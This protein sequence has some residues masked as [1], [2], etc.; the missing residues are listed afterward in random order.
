MELKEYVRVIKENIKPFLFLWFL[1]VG[2]S[3]VIFIQKEKVF[4]VV[5]SLDLARQEKKV[6]PGEELKNESIEYDH[7]YRMEADDRFGKKISKWMEDARIREKIF[8]KAKE[9]GFDD[10]LE[11]AKIGKSIRAEQLAPGYVKISWR[12]SN[13][14][15]AGKVALAVQT[16]LKEKVASLGEQEGNKTKEW[17]RLVFNEPI[18]FE[19]KMEL[20]L[21]LPLALLGGF[22]IANFIVLFWYYWKNEDDKIKLDRN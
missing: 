16:I 22:L 10:E 4:E 8:A 7:Y 5:V 13:P 12:I 14:A 3:L 18:V 20:K 6:Q 1:A 21:F 19:R 9:N 15:D 2:V 11:I 17:F